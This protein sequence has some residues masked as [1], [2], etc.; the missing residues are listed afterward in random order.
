MCRYSQTGS[1]LESHMKKGLM[2]MEERDREVTLFK[3][4]SGVENI[5][6]NTFFELDQSGRR[7][8]KWKVVKPRVK[9]RLRQEFFSQ[10]VINP[11]NQ[12]SD[13]IIN[14]N[15][16]PTLKKIWTRTGQRYGQPTLE[17]NRQLSE[18]SP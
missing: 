5:E 1:V 9:T 15:T 7:G 11:W 6:T 17:G 4:L 12:L 2:S 16:V 13:S 14:S 18:E 8:H 3:L 10:R